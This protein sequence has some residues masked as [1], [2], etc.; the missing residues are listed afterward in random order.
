MRRWFSEAFLSEQ[1]QREREKM[2]PG[3]SRLAMK[4]KMRPEKLQLKVSK[5]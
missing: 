5:G 4:V 3:K 1:I 2:P